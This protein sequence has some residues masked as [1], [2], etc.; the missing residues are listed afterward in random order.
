VTFNP[1]KIAMTTIVPDQ[2]NEE[3][4]K[5]AAYQPGETVEIEFQVVENTDGQLGV[6]V[7][8]C[9]IVPAEG[10]AAAEEEYTEPAPVAA[11]TAV[12]VKKGPNAVVIDVI[13][14]RSK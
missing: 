1:R 2:E 11:P 3:G 6:E 5:L 14:G 9:E 12:G 7:T 8:R 4:Q 13:R 10:E